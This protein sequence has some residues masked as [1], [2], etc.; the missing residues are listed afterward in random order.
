[1][2]NK[3]AVEHLRRALW[4][5]IEDGSVRGT[6]LEPIILTALRSTNLDWLQR[7]F[8]YVGVQDLSPAVQETKVGFLEPKSPTASGYEVS[9]SL[10][11]DSAM[12]VW[13]S[14]P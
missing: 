12:R 9:R 3:V 13:T 8:R 7:V 10:I 4:A 2:A 6:E 5:K 11:S 14:L 1:M